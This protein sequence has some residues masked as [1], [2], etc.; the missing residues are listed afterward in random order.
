MSRK[1]TSTIRYRVLLRQIISNL[2]KN[3]LFFILSCSVL[4]SFLSCSES[5]V[6]TYDGTDCIYFNNRTSAN[7]LSDSTEQTF[8]YIED[9]TIDVPVTIQTMG[10]AVDYDRKVNLKFEGD[11]VEGID[12]T[13][14]M[15]AVVKAGDYKIDYIVR[16]IKTDELSNTVKRIKLILTAN[17]YFS[18][19]FTHE[20]DSLSS[21]SPYVSS[22]Q[23]VIRFSN[24]FTVAPI[25]WNKDFAG[26]FSVRKLDLLVKLFPDVPRADYNVSGKISLAKWS[27][28]Q[29]EA[30]QYVYE[31]ETLYRMG[32]TYDEMIFEEDGSI[33][34]FG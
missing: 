19:N 7:V 5:E 2:N 1:E 13:L 18:T 4:F 15:E 12:Y 3:K 9:N 28:M 27:Y 11:A 26:T 20:G 10:R 21:S 23:Y 8:I 25:G 31:Q 6:P 24:Q 33:I 29:V 16:L 17:E 32:S 22:L 14:P 34:Y 30:N